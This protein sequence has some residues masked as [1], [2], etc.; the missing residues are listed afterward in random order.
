MDVTGATALPTAT[1]AEITKDVSNTAPNLPN[2]VSPVRSKLQQCSGFM[3]SKNH[4]INASGGSQ[5]LC[6][7]IPGRD[8]RSTT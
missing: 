4:D 2:S 1:L 6:A 5:R 8:L 7:S 3:Q